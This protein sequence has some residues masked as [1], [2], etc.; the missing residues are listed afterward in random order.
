M[1]CHTHT[2]IHSGPPL[3]HT[4]HT[5]TC[6]KRATKS[7]IKWHFGIWHAALGPTTSHGK[8][9]GH[10]THH[11]H[12][13]NHI[14]YDVLIYA[15]HWHAALRTTCRK[16]RRKTWA[17]PWN[18]SRIFHM[19][20]HKLYANIRTRSTCHWVWGFVWIVRV[21]VCVSRVTQYF[22]IPSKQKT[23][24]SWRNHIFRD[25]NARVPP[26]CW[27]YAMLGEILLLQTI[28]AHKRFRFYKCQW[29]L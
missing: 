22:N 17:T 18:S 24:A 21:W 25:K 16:T 12:P 19:Y 2:H 26:K 20:K 15:P 9:T 6:H 13:H 28:A 4:R 27:A 11:L 7:N 23:C 29:R 8:T 3:S 1:P 5:K 10:N 14:A